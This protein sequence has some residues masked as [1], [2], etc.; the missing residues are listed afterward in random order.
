MKSSESYEYSINIKVVKAFFKKNKWKLILSSFL[1]GIVAAF[2]SFLLPI[3]YTSNVK[4][5]PELQTKSNL[6]GFKALADL[7]GL[8]LDNMQVSEAI[9]P[10]LYPS[11][12][13]S[14]PFLL[15][16]SNIEIQAVDR[17][18][19]ETVEHYLGRQKYILND[20]N[21]ALFGWT[22]TKEKNNLVPGKIKI[23][24]GVVN[25]SREQNSLLRELSSRVK[26]NLDKKTGIISITVTM[27]DPVV[28]AWIAQYSTEY[29]TK[30]MLDYRNTKESGQVDFLK[31]QVS[32]A[33][34]RFQL[35]DRKLRQYKDGNRNPFLTE[36]TTGESKLQAELSIAQNLYA[37]L[38]RQLEQSRLKEKEQSPVLK[39]LDP[40]QVPLKRSSP[41]RT[42]ITLFG[43]I[44]GLLIGIGILFVSQK[45]QFS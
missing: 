15:E 19:Q 3:E 44:I 21:N 1:G 9:R 31:T 43:A 25:L 30:Y 10:D 6:G 36:A 41:K 18:T 33:K 40:P 22:V 16:L 34:E 35:A 11:V 20:I 45:Q 26:A 37:E 17:S 39:V 28:A 2:Y 29:L 24:K 23:I 14:I 27:P 38:A 13:E 5:L 32:E 8:N 12:L 42:M 7:A 4:I